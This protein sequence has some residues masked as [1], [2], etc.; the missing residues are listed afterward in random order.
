MGCSILEKYCLTKE[1]GKDL[2][3]NI[4]NFKEY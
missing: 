2:K 4:W 3:V 1:E